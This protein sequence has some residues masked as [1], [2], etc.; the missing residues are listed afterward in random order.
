M[1]STAAG[2]TPRAYK[3]PGLTGDIEKVLPEFTDPEHVAFLRGLLRDLR[4]RKGG[5]AGAGSCPTAAEAQ[6][7]PTSAPAEDGGALAPRPAAPR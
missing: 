6:R 1:E 7:V 4:Q 3:K 5:Q 2:A